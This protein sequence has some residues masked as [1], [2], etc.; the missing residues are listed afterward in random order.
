M[1]VTKI[2]K[3]YGILEGRILIRTD[4]GLPKK[5]M[6]TPRSYI[7]VNPGHMFGL[8]CKNQMESMKV[9]VYRMIYTY[10]WNVMC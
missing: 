1:C 10:I 8:I 6:Y 5:R 9:N 4:R 3:A 7:Y 2:R